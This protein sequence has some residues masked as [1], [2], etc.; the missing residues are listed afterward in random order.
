MRK[1]WT[2]Y[3][4][5]TLLVLLLL[6]PIVVLYSYS[7]ETSVEVIEKEIQEASLKRMSFF[8]SQVDNHVKQL[9][10]L[11]IVVSKDQTIKE[12]ADSNIPPVDRLRQ[13]ELQDSLVKKMGLLS[14]TSSWTNGLAIHLPQMNM[15]ISGD[16]SSVYNSS[17]LRENV[18]TS[19]KYHPKTE[20]DAY[21]SKFVLSPLISYRNPLDA[22]SLIEV[23]FFKQN[24]VTMLTEFKG[25]NQGEPFLYASRSEV[26]TSSGADTDMVGQMIEQLEQYPLEQ[27][28]HLLLKL[29]GEQYMVNYTKND[30]LGWYL[31]DYMPLHQILSPIFKARNVFYMAMGLLLVMSMVVAYFLYKQVQ[32]PIKMLLQ[33]VQ[34]IQHGK[35]SVRLNHKSRNEFDYLFYRFN[36]MAAEIERLIETV[37]KENIRFREAKLK[38]LQSQINPHFL[39][40]C[41]FFV[42]NM[43]AIDDKDSATAMVLNLAQ[44]YRYITKLES[45]LTP[46]KDEIR[47]VTSYL[48]IQNLRI[49]RFHYEIDI[50]SSMLNIEVPRLL[51]QP[52]VEN[53]ILHGVGSIEEYGIISIEGRET[54]SEFMI[55][56]DDNGT[57]LSE[58]KKQKLRERI[59]RPMD[60]ESSCGLWNVHQRLL[61]QYHKQAGLQF[62]NSPLGGLRVI[63]SWGKTA[64]AAQDRRNG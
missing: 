37:Y 5:I 16:Y 53:A 55:M 4:K 62:E 25:D 56:I 45:T 42:K 29:H 6:A 9:S 27:S 8:S 38:Q 11:A 57:G 39:Y 28:G 1:R 26:I 46:L 31:V 50:P 64:E 49:E 2:T 43:I 54:D 30:S 20:G 44:Y 51:I 48:D 60:G 17:T 12:L 36:E 23:R 7:N 24:I 41:L 63:I 10:I 18:T 19:W 33:G 22:E 58:E 40:N 21:F 14:A 47:L 59:T 61:F 52:I 13:L 15:D 3:N 34:G 32:S 35:Y